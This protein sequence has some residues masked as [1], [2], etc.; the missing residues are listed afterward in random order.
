MVTTQ[1]PLYQK[2]GK[3]PQAHRPLIKQTL[4]SWIPYVQYPLFCLQQPAGYHIIH[5]F[6]ALN[7]EVHPE[8]TKFKRGHETLM[9][10]AITKTNI[11][12]TMD[13][14]DHAWQMKMSLDQ[15]AQTAFTIP[16]QGQFNGI[17]CL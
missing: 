8:Q 16:G 7:R 6:N 9:N 3:I 2:L 13:L 10:F 14:F 17:I 15:A 1:E 5:D 12:L 4:D 11:V